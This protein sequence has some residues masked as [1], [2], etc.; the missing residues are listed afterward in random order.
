VSRNI[1]PPTFD[2]H[3]EPCILSYVFIQQITFYIVGFI[4]YIT[5]KEQ[6]FHY[7]YTKEN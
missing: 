3:C 7:N 4:I 5:I 1:P 6:S 2:E